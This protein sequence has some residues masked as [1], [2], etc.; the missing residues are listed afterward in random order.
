M[1]VSF[2]LICMYV[3]ICAYMYICVYVYAH[4]YLCIHVCICVHVYTCAYVYI[5]ICGCMC[6]YVRICVYMCIYVHVGVYMCVYVYM[7]IYMCTYVYVGFGRR[8][9]KVPSPGHASPF[10]PPPGPG[11]EAEG[12][13]GGCARDSAKVLM[14]PNT[15]STFMEHMQS[16]KEASKPLYGNDPLGK[17]ANK[18]VPP[19]CFWFWCPK[20]GFSSA[21]GSPTLWMVQPGKTFLREA[22]LQPL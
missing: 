11:P 9:N 7:R 18:C 21:G 13:E 14:A 6:V 10:P 1:L 19:Q 22:F 8:Q 17:T 16:L 4:L 12:A 15:E 2:F 20:E 5:C 3:F